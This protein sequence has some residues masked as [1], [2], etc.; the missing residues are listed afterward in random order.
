MNINQI[1]KWV[2]SGEDE[3]LE[4]KLKANHPEKII[5]E[6]V[7]FANHQGGHLIVGVSD[8]R[9]IVG[10]QY[11]NEAHHQI[12]TAIERY[13]RP[14]FD[15]TTT[16][17]PT[18]TTD[19]YLLIYEIRKSQNPPHFVE[20]PDVGRKAYFRLGESSIQAS[21]EL[22]SILR[23]SVMA[24][25]TMIKYGD[26][27]RHLMQL[28]DNEK[29]VTVRSFANSANISLK[30]AS[31]T[32]VFMVMA[33]VLLIHPSDADDQFSMAP[34]SSVPLPKTYIKID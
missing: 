34:L 33:G 23:K 9:K 31:E 5:R 13:C 15:Y 4:F 14:L 11:P 1:K 18:H 2:S 20:H 25:N 17:L 24:K 26:I 21:R 6:M 28:L 32:L 16:I 10:L 30:K 7:A 8:N 3:R 29:T 27:E 12:S 22:C 19:R